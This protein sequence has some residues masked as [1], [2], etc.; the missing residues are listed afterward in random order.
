MLIAGAVVVE[1]CEVEAIASR[2]GSRKRPNDY[3]GTLANE[4]DGLCQLVLGVERGF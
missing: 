4:V 3:T 2:E 1:F